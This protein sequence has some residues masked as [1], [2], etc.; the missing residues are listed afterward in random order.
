MAEIPLSKQ[1]AKI[2]EKLGHLTM[3]WKPAQ[4]LDTGIP[5]LNMVVGHREKGL[6]YGSQLEIAGWESNGKS[7]LALSL[8]ALAQNDGA[9]VIWLDLERSWDPEWATKRGLDVDRL[10]VIQPY[11]G[12]FGKKKKKK[13]QVDDEPDVK[14]TTRLSVAQDLLEEVEAVVEQFHG[15]FDKFF[16]VVDSIPAIL[17]EAEE[18][19]GITDQNMRTKMDL[20]LF[21]SSTAR[22]WM[23]WAQSYCVH[24][25]WINQ[26]RNR[27]DPFDPEYTPGGNAMRFYCH[28][29]VRISR[30]KGKVIKRKGVTVGMQGFITNYKNKSGSPERSRVGFKLMFDGPLEFLPAGDLEKDLE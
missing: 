6:A 19:G 14:T 18:A 24:I 16:L 1:F 30:A 4:Y 9:L 8:A 25:V 15:K 26:L 22:R 13:G 12:K 27:P 10:I 20:P 23:T 5:D 21:L 29:R 11:V 2:R 7:A 3:D 28:T 17:T